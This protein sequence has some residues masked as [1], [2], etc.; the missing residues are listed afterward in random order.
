MRSH[1]CKTV[2]KECTT[3]HTKDVYKDV[4]EFGL[5]P[6][7]TILSTFR[8]NCVGFFC[9]AEAHTVCA[10]SPSCKK[11]RWTSGPKELA[12]TIHQTQHKNSKRPADS[13]R[14]ELFSRTKTA[15]E[16]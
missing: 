14:Y 2:N 6:A 10:E 13:E 15:H 5:E 12:S 1:T 3:E 9:T 4:K 7:H 16:E 11:E 8:T